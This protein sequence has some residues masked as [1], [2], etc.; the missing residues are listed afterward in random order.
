MRLVARASPWAC[1]LRIYVVA[2]V[3]VGNLGRTL[4][5]ARSPI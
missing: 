5:P 1:P 4:A 3:D 2:S